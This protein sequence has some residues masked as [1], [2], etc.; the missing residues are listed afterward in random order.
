M[1]RAALG[2]FLVALIAA[3]FGFGGVAGIAMEGAELFFVVGIILVVL[4]LVF[5]RSFLR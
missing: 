3:L 1:F 2:L 4:A 5:G